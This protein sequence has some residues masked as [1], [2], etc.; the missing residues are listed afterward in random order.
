MTDKQTDTSHKKVRLKRERQ[1]DT[2]LKNV[3]HKQTDAPLQKVR[4][5]CGRQAER[6][7]AQESEG[8]T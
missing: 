2:R 8:K 6:H 7:Y 3:T 1:T 5:K 4:I